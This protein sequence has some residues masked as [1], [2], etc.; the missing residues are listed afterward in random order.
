MVRKKELLEKLVIAENKIDGLET[1]IFRISME[2]DT[3]A[4]D[5]FT[6]IE[7]HDILHEKARKLRKIVGYSY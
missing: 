7:I 2:L 1:K 3:L 5:S 6:G 4:D